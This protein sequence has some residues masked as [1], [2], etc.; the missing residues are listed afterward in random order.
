MAGIGSSNGGGNGNHGEDRPRVGE[1]EMKRPQIDD[2]MMEEAP[3]STSVGVSSSEGG[4]DGHA[5]EI[6]GD[7]D[8]RTPVKEG[9][10]PGVRLGPEAMAMA[11]VVVDHPVSPPRDPE[12]GKGPTIVEETP[13]EISVERVEFKPPVGSS[14]H[15]PITSG[16]LAE[17][18]GEVVL[19]QLLEESL[20][21]VAIVLAAREER[22]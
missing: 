5:T 10:M 22:F 16:D 21:V 9:R 11:A 13:R 6:G 1:T 15:D 4:G 17:F 20:A 12:R 14:R 7:R 2:Q 8:R 19:A 18:V 3:T